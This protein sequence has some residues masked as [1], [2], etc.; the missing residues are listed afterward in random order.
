MR[1][2]LLP[3]LLLLTARSCRTT[4][5]VRTTTFALVEEQG[6]PCW[7]M[8]RAVTMAAEWLGF[9]I[10]RSFA[11]GWTPDMM[12]SCTDYAAFDARIRSDP[13]TAL[14]PD[15]M[16]GLLP[17]TSKVRLA[18]VLGPHQDWW[19]DVPP[20]IVVH[21]GTRR[22]AFEEFFQQASGWGTPH[23]WLIK[24]TTELPGQEMS[25]HGGKN[26]RLVEA[27]EATHLWRV[28]HTRRAE[29]AGQQVVAQRLADGILR[30]NGA[31]FDFRVHVA[32]VGNASG[33]SALWS[34]AQ[35]GVARLASQPSTS[36]TTAASI[37]TNQQM[38]GNSPRHVEGTQHLKAHFGVKR[39]TR[40][41]VAILAV[42]K[43][44]LAVPSIGLPALSDRKI[45]AGF[46]LIGCDF[47]LRTPNGAPSTSPGNSSLPD[48]VRP[49][50]LECNAH[51]GWIPPL[52]YL[53]P[54]H[55]AKQMWD[56]N[57]RLH[58]HV[59]GFLAALSELLLLTKSKV[60]CDGLNSVQNCRP[61]HSVAPSNGIWKEIAFVPWSSAVPFARPSPLSEAIPSWALES[62]S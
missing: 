54:P 1:V 30:I 55:R 49:I 59:R 31:V 33:V 27:K 58:G 25:F 61:A 42:L 10:N 3:P 29:L 16:L 15:P 32:I 9:G 50:L 38:Q 14:V 22:E 53:H 24:P 36:V 19:E 26:I 18:E 2:S 28:I 13:N 7:G 8:A 45:T 47:L 39:W 17:G 34:P 21:N 40:V 37:M 5:S 44:Y 43:R 6:K 62:G 4:V 23:T 20:A 56:G 51:P 52:R 48:G 60:P 41:E 46:G 35:T 57:K 12:S 11:G